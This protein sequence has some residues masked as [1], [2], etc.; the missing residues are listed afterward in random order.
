MPVEDD[1]DGSLRVKRP[2]RVLRAQDEG[3]GWGPA[4]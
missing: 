1:G 2:P 4:G 3:A